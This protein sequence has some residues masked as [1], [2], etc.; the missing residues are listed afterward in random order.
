MKKE[1]KIIIIFSVLLLLNILIVSASIKSSKIL[2][3]TDGVVYAIS[4]S[5]LCPYLNPKPDTV[6]LYIV[7][8]QDSWSQD[9]LT[10]V[11]GSPSEVPNSKFP[12]PKQKIWE[13]PR[14]GSYDIIIDCIENGQYDP[15]EPLYNKGFTVIAKR[16]IVRAS[17]TPKPTNFSWQYD[18]EEPDLI[19]EILRLN[20]STQN[21]DIKLNN[22][23][24]EFNSPSNSNINLEVYIDKNNNGKLN[25]NDVL[26]GHVQTSEKKVTFSLDYTLIQDN[27]E[28]ILFVYNMNQ[29]SKN[30]DY[31]IKVISLQSI[32][33]FSE[34]TIISSGTPIESSIM[35][36]VGKK[37]CLG[38]LDLTL[39]P[40]PANQNSVVT[41]KISNLTGCDNKDASLRTSSCHLNLNKEVGFCT[42]KNNKCELN[43][44]SI[45][46]RYYACIDKNNDN[47]KSDFGE[48]VSEDLVVIIP[49]IGG[50]QSSIE[51]ED[52]EQEKTEESATPIT[53][54]VV[55]GESR[56]PLQDQNSLLFLLEVTLLLILFV[57]ILILFRL[58]DNSASKEVQKDE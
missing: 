20:L 30:G 34:E 51:Q 2:Y 39:T 41:A 7:E 35:T 40:N 1:S 24:I 31:S 25:L 57:L 58:K 16:G 8:N 46:G 55:A 42:I 28:E 33:I 52:N 49:I 21:E 14:K 12:P 53:G 22:I 37:T 43:I 11:R 10:D 36:V 13:N 45:K 23:T 27:K 17:K 48:S 47:D 26:I 54:N 9:L 6:K 32:G 18:P 4:T 19:N 3:N 44:Q 5:E 15:L 38:K 29:D 50:T 56:I